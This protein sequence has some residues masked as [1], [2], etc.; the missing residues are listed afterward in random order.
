MTMKRLV[1]GL[2]KTRGDAD[3]AVQRVLEDGH[4]RS[5][6]SL[7][8]GAAGGVMVVGPITAARAGG[9]KGGLTGA[10]I[11]TGEPEQRAEIDETSLQEGEILVGVHA[12]ST[13]EVD[14]IECIF[15]DFCAEHIRVRNTGEDPSSSFGWRPIRL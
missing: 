6:I 12:R 14:R 1:T 4:V 2:L 5:D 9:A 10:L 15:E 7:L 8:L 13:S 3:A 11:D